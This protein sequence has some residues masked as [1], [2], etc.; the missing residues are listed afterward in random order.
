MLGDTGLAWMVGV[1]GGDVLDG[2][3]AAAIEQ[4][5]HVRV[6]LEDHAGP[7]T[8]SNEELVARV[9]EL[10]RAAGTSRRHLRGSPLDPAGLSGQ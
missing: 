2:L 9:V 6:G 1:Q 10:A 7:T 5:G 4:G 3:A 8:P